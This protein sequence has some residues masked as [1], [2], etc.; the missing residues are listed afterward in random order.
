MNLARSLAATKAKVRSSGAYHCA[1]IKHFDREEERMEH[2]T[3]KFADQ[4][5]GSL[6]GFDRLVFRATLRRIAY[7][8]VMA[9]IPVG[10]PSPADCLRGA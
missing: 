8:F 1:S 3:A 2:F 5:A 9:G 7:L 10:H 4:I 6:S